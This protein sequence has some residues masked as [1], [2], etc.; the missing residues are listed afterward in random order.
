M[1][2]IKEQRS[3]FLQ[4]ILEGADNAAAD[5]CDIGNAAKF[6]RTALVSRILTLVAKAPSLAE[7]ETRG[8]NLL[9][10]RRCSRRH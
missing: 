8:S 7:N 2:K 5:A 6:D 3:R 10:F 1:L 9:T 4:E